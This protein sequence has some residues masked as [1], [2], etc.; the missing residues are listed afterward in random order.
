M[1][2]AAKDKYSLSFAVFWST[3]CIFTALA[4]HDYFLRPVVS[5]LD[6]GFEPH[7]VGPTGFEIAQGLVLLLGYGAFIVPLVCAV[8]ALQSLMQRT[9]SARLSSLSLSLCITMVALMNILLPIH[10]TQPVF[11]AGGFLG[12]LIVDILFYYVDYAGTVLLLSSLLLLLIQQIFHHQIERICCLLVAGLR[13]IWQELSKSLQ[14]SQSVTDTDSASVTPLSTPEA[15]DDSDENVTTRRPTITIKQQPKMPA[16]NA[17]QSSARL[18]PVLPKQK[19]L[20]RSASRQSNTESVAEAVKPSQA[21]HSGPQISKVRRSKSH[22]AASQASTESAVGDINSL[23]GSTIEIQ[24]LSG[25]PPLDLLNQDKLSEKIKEDPRKLQLLADMIEQKLKDFGVDAQVMNILLGPIITRFEIQPSPG[26]KA[27]KITGLAKDLARSLSVSSV[28]VVEVITGKTFIG[29]EIPNKKRVTV[30][31]KTIFESDAF[32][33]SKSQ[34]CLALGVDISGDPVVVDLAKMPHLLVAGTTGSGKSVG[35]NTLLLSLLYKTSPE[36]LKLILVD[37]KML[38]FAVYEGIPHLLTPVVTDMNDASYAL[39][40]CVDEMERRYRL[41]AELGV[42]NI[43]GYN[44]KVKRMPNIEISGSADD[45][46]VHKHL[47]YIVVIADEFADMMMMVGKKVEQL[48]ARLAQK[49]RAAGIHLIL[50]TQRPSV[51][52][53]TG[54]IKANI[55]TRMSF[56]VSSKIDSRTILDQQ[57]AESLLGYGDMLYLTPGAGQPVRCHGAFVSDEAVAGVVEHLRS[58]GTPD[59]IEIKREPEAQSLPQSDMLSH[60]DQKRNKDDSLYDQIVDFVPTSRKVSTSSVQRR[61]RIGYNRA[62]VMVERMESEGV[63]SAMDDNGQRKVLAP[64]PV[65]QVD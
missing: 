56:Q 7:T 47:P 23:S 48:I 55:P 51:D 32:Q 21:I 65:S 20:K 11:T 26:T 62:S 18:A 16:I 6:R 35:L 39:S 12:K 4:L 61:F 1:S 38:E 13:P 33:S 28:R 53:I 37:P 50:A 43:A 59:H 10:T 40:W 58:T 29:I 34:L 57:G 64:P 2:T 19:T 22:Q 46:E 42:R 31:L 44:D 9:L 45:D 49:A 15:I 14:V 17:E 54:L 52:V 30:S 3:A 63:V 41:M 36:D 5:M 27:S 24:A 25:P 8:M 60:S